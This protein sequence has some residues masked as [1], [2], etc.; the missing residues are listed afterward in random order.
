MNNQKADYVVC[1]KTEED[2]KIMNERCRKAG[3]SVPERN[4]GKGDKRFRVYSDPV[5]DYIG[6]R[7]DECNEAKLVCFHG[8]PTHI[9][10][11]TLCTCKFKCSTCKKIF[12]PL[13]RKASN[14]DKRKK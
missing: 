3:F 2:R 7:C 9:I 1:I 6:I 5:V 12:I 4:T 13:R 11:Y 14:K 8:C 10:K